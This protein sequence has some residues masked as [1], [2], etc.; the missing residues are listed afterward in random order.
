MCWLAATISL[1]VS[2]TLP[3]SPTHVPGSRTAKSPSR[4]L[5]RLVSMTVRSKEPSVSFGFP[6]LAFPPLFFAMVGGGGFPGLLGAISLSEVLFMISPKEGVVQMVSLYPK[7]SL[8]RIGFVRG[9]IGL[10]ATGSAHFG[11]VRL[12]ADR[13]TGARPGSRSANLTFYTYWYHERRTTGPK[14]FPV[15]MEPNVPALRAFREG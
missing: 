13:Q 9:H 4:M 5:C 7:T 3:A 11:G 6:L 14:V 2:A 8:N 10:W 12:S 15:V 1:N